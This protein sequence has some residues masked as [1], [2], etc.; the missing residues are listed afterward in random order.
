MATFCLPCD[1]WDAP[2][3][4]L[5][6]TR[7]II[8]GH[9]MLTKAFPG[10]KPS[11]L[12]GPCFIHCFVP[13]ERWSKICEAGSLYCLGIEDHLFFND[14]KLSAKQIYRRVSCKW[15]GW[16]L[17]FLSLGGRSASGHTLHFVSLI[18]SPPLHLCLSSTPLILFSRVY[19]HACSHGDLYIEHTSPILRFKKWAPLISGL[20]LAFLIQVNPPRIIYGGANGRLI[21][22]KISVPGLLRSRALLSRQRYTY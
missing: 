18:S 22:V 10:A 9:R 13:V 4:S 11:Q 5:H 3:G 20:Y 15:A 19:F 7:A 12:H 17:T 21:F 6:G 14:T 1:E 8:C 2:A 16:I